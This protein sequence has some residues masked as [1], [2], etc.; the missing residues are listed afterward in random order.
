MK[1]TKLDNCVESSG[2][3]PE[4]REP[5]QKKFDLPKVLP[6]NPKKSNKTKTPET[7]GVK[8]LNPPFFHFFLQ[9]FG[10][11]LVGLGQ[12]SMFEVTDEN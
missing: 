7:F 1:P 2:G 3:S 8:L 6:G 11:S 9:V 5:K 4:M 10:I 12:V